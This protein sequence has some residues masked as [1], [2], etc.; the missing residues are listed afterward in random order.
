MSHPT[1]IP[2]TLDEWIARDA[3]PF[4]VDSP[5]IFNA[6]VDK[7]IA[8]DVP[9]ALGGEIRSVSLFFSDIA[10]FSGFSE[11][12]AP[13]EVVSLMNE[14]LSAMTDIIQEHGGFV[15]KYIGDAIV[16]VFGAPVD[17]VDHAANAVN[18]ALHCR[19]GR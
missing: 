10:G 12:M 4:S 8:S 1:P 7:M 14:Y 16:A 15:D 11:K 5:S 17:D 19:A 18:A 2:A 6:A 13:T 9:P 3:T